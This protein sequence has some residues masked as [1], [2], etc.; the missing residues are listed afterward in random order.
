MFIAIEGPD[1]SGK[2]TAINKLDNIDSPYSIYTTKEPGCQVLD[3]CQSMREIILQSDNLEDKTELYL[4]LADRIEHY[5]N[6]IKNQLDKNDFVVTDRYAL[7]TALYQ[8]GN[9]FFNDEEIRNLYYRLHKF[10]DIKFPDL[11]IIFDISYN[12]MK[13]RL[14]DQKLDR[15]ENKGEDYHKNLCDM[16]KDN[17]LIES[18]IYPNCVRIDAEQSKDELFNEMWDIIKKKRIEN[19]ADFKI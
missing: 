15:I 1:G 5:H 11:T 14:S 18:E 4:F 16:Y 2:T 7:S 12:V 17:R 13:D 3:A 6:V 8:F 9:D 10:G 19:E